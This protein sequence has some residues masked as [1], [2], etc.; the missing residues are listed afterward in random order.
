M[1]FHG[2]FDVAGGHATPLVTLTGVFDDWPDRL[3][4]ASEQRRFEMTLKGYFAWDGSCALCKEFS[5]CP[6]PPPAI[7]D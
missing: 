6:P 2:S 5:C 4:I 7:G 1:L 3:A